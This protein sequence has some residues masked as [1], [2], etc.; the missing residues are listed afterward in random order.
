MSGHLLLEG[1]AE[2]GGMMAEPDL[3]AIELAGGLDARVCIIPAAAAPDNNHL[4]AGQNGVRWF[5]HLDAR[6][7]TSLPLIDRASA[8]QPSVATA[9]RHARLV[10]LLGGFPHH[11]GQTLVGSL[12]WQAM[13]E[14][15]RAGAVLGGSSAGAM[16]LCGHYYD[17]FAGSIA[18]GLGLVPG[19]CIIPHHDT[20]GSGWAPRLAALLPGDTLI[21]I[22]EQTGMIDDGADGAWH[23][24]GR[25][26]VT[27][28]QDGEARTYRSG[29]DVE[30]VPGR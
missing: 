22:D 26:V 1:G 30:I 24:Y 12:S 27:V 9:L 11:L 28:Y 4:R 8:D 16:V 21:G 3:R 14:A 17:P 15:Y 19:A 7:V 29:E 6:S 23:V 5:E 10:Y 18:D 25:G 20:F 2:F 13:L